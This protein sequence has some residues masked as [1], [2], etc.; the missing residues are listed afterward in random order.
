MVAITRAPLEDLDSDEYHGC[1]LC[2][3]L[4]MAPFLSEKWAPVSHD[5]TAECSF[6]QRDSSDKEKVVDLALE[7]DLWLSSEFCKP[8]YDLYAIMASFF[9]PLGGLF[10]RL[11]ALFRAHG[12]ASDKFFEW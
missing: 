3:D 1:I 4:D 5:Q 2:T 12:Q 9:F 6:E 8:C 10:L 7:S 11:R